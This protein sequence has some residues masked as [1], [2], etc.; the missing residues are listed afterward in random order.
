M[1]TNGAL[2]HDFSIKGHKHMI[3]GGGGYGGGVVKH[4][5]DG[6]DTQGK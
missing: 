5:D 3:G 4:D 1:L 2:V 6:G